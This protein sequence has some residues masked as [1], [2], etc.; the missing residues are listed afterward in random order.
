MRIKNL[1][2][3][4]WYL[5]LTSCAVAASTIVQNNV[6][7]DL[8]WRMRHGLDILTHGFSTKENYSYTMPSFPFV[9][10]AWGFDI[11]TGWLSSH[12][13]YQAMVAFI[14]L[15]TTVALA[16]ATWKN[17]ERWLGT[18]Q[19]LLMWA[20]AIG[21]FGVRAQVF[22][23]PLLFLAVWLCLLP[24]KD[25]LR[26]RWLIPV[27]GLL[28]SNLHGSFPIFF[29][30]LTVRTIAVWWEQHR[31]DWVDGALILSL[32]PLSLLNPYGIGLWREVWLTNTDT[33]L[34][35]TIGEWRPMWTQTSDLTLLYAI[36]LAATATLAVIKKSW[37]ILV[38]ILVTAAMGIMSIRHAPLFIFTT[39]LCLG[40]LFALYDLPQMWEVLKKDKL[41]RRIAKTLGTAFILF[42]IWLPLNAVVTASPGKEPTDATAYL[43]DTYPDAVVFNHYNWGG[44][45]I[46][47]LPNSKVFIDG[48]MPSWRWT[49]P[50]GE[51]DWAHQ[52]WSKIGDGDKTVFDRDVALFHI[53]TVLWPV[54]TSKDKFIQL[55]HDEGWK[56]VYGDDTA[57]IFRKP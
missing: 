24:A 22:A 13:G 46:W 29:L 30:L 42:L 49:A 35:N 55:L 37:Q 17:R 32:I 21:F 14:V 39:A 4:T 28:W 48:R 3:Y 5:A 1:P 45:Q 41:L 10:H 40:P 8:W 52:D 44:Y 20:G 56:Q 54:T 16:V 19:I 38:L 43:R 6:D 47:N 50:A 25:W 23:W 7:P 51:L 26:L 12:G 31:I 33:T 15:I 27:I 18:I 11:L 34:H 2:L 53:D 57:I 9:S 36:I